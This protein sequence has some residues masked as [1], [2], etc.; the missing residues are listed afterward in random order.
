[1]RHISMKDK[2]IATL[3]H[4]GRGQ[5]GARDAASLHDGQIEELARL[6]LRV[7]SYFKVPCDIEWGLSHGEFYL[8]QSR[9]I[10]ASA[11]QRSAVDPEFREKVRQEE[12]ARARSIA[13]PRGTVW[14]RYNLAEILPDPTPMTW[15]I[16]RGFMSGRGGFG[17]MYRDL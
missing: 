7:E 12:V 4:D 9:P 11:R 5:S 17:L 13:D 2:V 1:E 15:A 3:A 14:S 10:R 6:G 8:L 16:V